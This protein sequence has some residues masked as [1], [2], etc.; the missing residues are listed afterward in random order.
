MK[1]KILGLVALGLLG[2][3]QANATLIDKNN[4]VVLDSSTMLEWEQ[5]TNPNY[6]NWAE[7]GSYATSL[8]LSGGGWRLPTIDELKQLYLNISATTGCLD[9]TGPQGPF[10]EIGLGYWT[11]AQYFAGQP[12]AFYVGF[13]SGPNYVAG[14]FQTSQANVW[15]VRTGTPVPEPGTFALLGLGLAGLGLSRRRK[16]I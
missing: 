14:L 1:A 8:A 11:T 3:A 13:W 10:T 5:T 12:G 16:A 4:G 15:A 2:S 6:V 7:A 9:C